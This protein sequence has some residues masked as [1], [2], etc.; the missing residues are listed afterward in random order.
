V[1][2]DDDGIGRSWEAALAYAEGLTL[3]GCDDWRLPDAKELQ[4]ILDYARSPDTTGSAAIDPVFGASPIVDEGGGTNYPF[5]WSST[6]HANWTAVPGLWAA[7]V[8]FG[9]ALGWMMDPYPPPPH[10][11]LQDVHGAGAQRSDPKDGNPSDYPYG[12]GP[13]GDVVRVF[14]HVR[15][16]R[17]APVAA[18]EILVENPAT[19][20]I[21]FYPSCPAQSIHV[22]TGRLSDLRVDGDFTRAG[23]L[24]AFQG[25]G[26]DTRSN[27]APGDGYYYLA[28]GLEA[29]AA[30]G[31][32]DARGV[33]PDPR[34]D[35]EARDACP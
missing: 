8:C 10:W 29:C 22:V 33:T 27:P 12:H 16:V 20:L 24:G 15:A 6:T 4:S 21:G 11:A 26:E 3:A 9:E 13:Q 1:A 31:Y 35:L 14:N 2:Q 28:K 7:Y 30:R 5:Y 34:D 23:C 18:C 25:T 17:G 32:G 19:V